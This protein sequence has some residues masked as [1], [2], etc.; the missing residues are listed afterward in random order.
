[1]DIYTPTR[2]QIDNV[3]FSGSED[4]T[5]T[6]PYWQYEAVMPVILESRKSSHIMKW[7]EFYSSSY[8]AS[9]GNYYSR[10]LSHADVQESIPT[11]FER[12][13]FKGSIQTQDTTPDGEPAFEYFETNP[14]RM[15]VTTPGHEGNIDVV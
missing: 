2:Y 3:K 12:L 11:S 10:S 7:D 9:I 6:N 15:V 5:F 13:F 4:I 14:N 1:M 8:S